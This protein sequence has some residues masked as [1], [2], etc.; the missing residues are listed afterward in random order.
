MDEFHVN[1][2]L[3]S[4]KISFK[5]LVP[6]LTLTLVQCM[7]MELDVGAMMVNLH[8]RHG[9]SQKCVRIGMPSWWFLQ[10]VL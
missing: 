1:V 2:T 5:E 10:G 4:L 6:L 8:N 7:S 3:F 9:S